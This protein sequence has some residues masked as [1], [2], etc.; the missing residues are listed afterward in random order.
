MGTGSAVAA[1]SMSADGPSNTGYFQ[2]RLALSHSALAGMRVPLS[3]VKSPL[4]RIISNMA[5]KRAASSAAMSSAAL[6][7]NG[8]SV[9]GMPARR[10]PWM[11][12]EFETNRKLDR[13]A[14]QQRR[15]E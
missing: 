7:P 12:I 2:N 6:A 13:R 14:S 9:T 15:V 5:L 1:A 4:L 11:V 8:A 10:H 3:A